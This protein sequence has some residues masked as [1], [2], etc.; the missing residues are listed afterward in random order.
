M[1]IELFNVND[2]VITSRGRFGR[3][4]KVVIKER[5]RVFYEL[6]MGSKIVTVDSSL[7]RLAKHTTPLNVVYKYKHNNEV[8]E[9]KDVIHVNHD[10]ELYNSSHESSIKEIAELYLFKKLGIKVEVTLIKTV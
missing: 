2:L 4:L 10:T 8:Y 3:I 6:M 1:P 7:C 9:E 5:D